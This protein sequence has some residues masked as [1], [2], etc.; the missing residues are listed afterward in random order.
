MVV[1][2]GKCFLES[3]FMILLSNFLQSIGW[4]VNKQNDK[5]I[6][7]KNKKTSSKTGFTLICYSFK[8]HYIFF[9]VKSQT[10]IVTKT[11]LT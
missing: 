11:I 8:I 9:L 4:S 2:S 1:K 7:F 5:E 3:E 10:K 6:Y